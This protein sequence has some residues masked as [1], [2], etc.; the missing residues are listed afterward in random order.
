M[1]RGTLPLL[2]LLA[3]QREDFSTSPIT[4]DP[5]PRAVVEAGARRQRDARSQLPEAGDAAASAPS[6]SKQILF[7]DLH[8]HT[9]F[10]WDGFLFSLPLVGGEGAHPPNDACDFARHCA[11]LDFYALTDH[12]ES[13]SVEH[14][15]ASKESVR[16]CNALAGD[17]ESPDLVAFTGFEWSQAGLTP[18][19]HWGHRCV[20]F[21]GTGESELPAR[22]IGSGD[23]RSTRLEM[24]RLVGMVRL[25]QPQYWG[26]YGAYLDYLSALTEREFCPQGVDTRELPLHCAE[27]APT[28]RVLHEKLDQWGFEALEIPHGTSWGAYT[29]AT[30]TIDKHLDPKHFDPRRQR[31]IEIMSGH[32]NSELYRN[33]RAWEVREDGERICPAPTPDYL[34]CCW[35]AGEI[36]RSRCGDLPEAE[37]EARVEQARQY[38]MGAYLRQ[39]QVFPDAAPEAW[40][41]CGQCRDCFK[42]AYGHR[43]RESVQ[44]AMAL[45]QSAD[46][47]LAG[48]TTEGETT[49]SEPRRFRYGFVA[50]SDGHTGRPGTGYKQIER[51]MMTD[52]VGSPS[53]IFGAISKLRQRM[54]DPRQPAELRP[55]PIGVMGSD[56]R[57]QSFLYPGGLAAVHAAGR[58]RVAI[59]DAIE[60]REV[61]GTSGPRILLWFDLLNGPTGPSPMGSEL[62]LSATPRFEVR[63]VGSFEQEPGCPGWSEAGLPADRLERLCRGECYNPGARR[64]AIRAIEVVRIRPQQT[65][66]EEVGPL[67]EDPWRR[68]E[69]KP[70]PAG[71]VLRFADA[72]F[73]AAGRDTLYYVRALEFAS[74]A[75]NGASLRTEFD[76]AGKATAISVCRG[77]GSDAGCPAPVQERAWSS[78]IFVNAAR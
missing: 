61:Y 6:P 17:P 48:E 20:I 35:Q 56:M 7:G 78:P 41:D 9:S 23:G 69:C 73:A 32:G 53:P 38:A 31:V 46:A 64:R 70:D 10:S 29:P 34:P 57:V 58:G 52:I 39:E 55:G 25:L 21:P 2:L 42:S 13:L 4:G 71:C 18:E 60:R 63:A 43:P 59:W 49:A 28:P 16:Q 75:I 8:V 22:P 27:A 11:N 77:P 12:A 45:S 68:F 76:A 5:K 62:T 54:D 14:W 37:C 33:W 30:A 40:L 51:S 24:Q 47:A 50:S 15:D 36:M 26:D 67:I 65:P 74:P 72:D 66:G 1:A 44:Y 3:C 19:S